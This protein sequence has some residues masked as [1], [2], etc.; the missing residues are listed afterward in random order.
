[1]RDYGMS[2]EAIERNYGCVAEYNRCMEEREEREY[3]YEPTYEEL[4][5]DGEYESDPV[6]FPRETPLTRH[7]EIGDRRIQYG[8]YGG[9]TTYIVKEI[10]RDNN[11]ILLAE[12]WID[13]D[14]TG[15]RPAEWHELVENEDGNEMALEWESKEYGKFWIHA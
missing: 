5:A 2:L 4:L 10:D 9:I 15:T 14:G 3:S 8:I 11:R 12:E 6:P 1:M 13:V 7:F